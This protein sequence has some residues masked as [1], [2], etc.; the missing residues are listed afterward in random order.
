M[1]QSV[2]ISTTLYLPR[3]LTGREIISS[4]QHLDVPASVSFVHAIDPQRPQYQL[5][6]FASS[7]LSGHLQVAANQNGDGLLPAELYKR[8]VVKHRQWSGGAVRIDPNWEQRAL[9][10]VKQL[11]DR[12]GWILR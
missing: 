2:S 7:E 8:L 11:A 6:G 12:L 4:I 10:S 3:E 1:T 9:V 5:I